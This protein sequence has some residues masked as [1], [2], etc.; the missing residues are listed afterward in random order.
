MVYGTFLIIEACEKL[1]FLVDINKSTKVVSVHDVYNNKIYT[2]NVVNVESFTNEFY[3]NAG[4]IKYRQS[5]I[6]GYIHTEIKELQK[7]P[8]FIKKWRRIRLR[9]SNLAQLIG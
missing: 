2:F 3:A 4:K 8:L 7:D 5:S 6:S 1:G 9:N